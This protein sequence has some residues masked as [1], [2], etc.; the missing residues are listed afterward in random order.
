MTQETRNFLL[1]LAEIDHRT[2]QLHSG[3]MKLESHVPTIYKYVDALSNKI[4]TP[5]LI[6]LIYPKIILNNID[7]GLSSYL[8]LSNSPKWNIWQF[9]Q[10]LK[11]HPIIF[12]NTGDF[13]DDTPCW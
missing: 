9:Y 13:T 11:V 7:K 12:K 8:S 1:T 3:L 10:F 4:V 5:T 2:N 6:D